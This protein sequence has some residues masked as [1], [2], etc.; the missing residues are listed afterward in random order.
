M[1]TG[2]GFRV[3]NL[4]ISAILMCLVSL[5]IASGSMTAHAEW[6]KAS[7]PKDFEDCATA[8][9]QPSLGK[10]AKADILSTCDAKFTGRRKPGGGYTYFDFMQNRTFDIAGPNPTQGELK[11]IDQEYLG[12]LETQR[13]AA[14]HSALTQP[15]PNIVPPR[16]AIVAAKPAVPQQVRPI[17]TQ[18]QANLQKPVP[19][20]KQDAV[21]RP[22]ADLVRARKDKACNDTL[23]CGWTKLT[24]TVSSLRQTLLASAT[25]AGIRAD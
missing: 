1:P 10:D 19:A 4:R 25:K 20:L 24:T 6:W 3:A 15:Q 12:Y 23:S 16:P 11:R 7:S 22:P 21:Q 5:G 2:E 18:Q 17:Q 13:K 8:A 9:E 14:I